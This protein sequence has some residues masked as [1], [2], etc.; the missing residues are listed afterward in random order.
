MDTKDANHSIQCKVEQ[1]ENHC[2]SEN[3][4]GLDKI[5][6]NTHESNPTVPQC[7]D[8]ESFVAKK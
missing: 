6:V 5:D 3:Y 8:C 7:V 1:C 2:G 4:C